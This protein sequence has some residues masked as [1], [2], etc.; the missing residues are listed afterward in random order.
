MTK[1]R[2]FHRLC[3]C[4]VFAITGCAGGGE[5]NNNVATSTAIN[6]T[7][8]TGVALTG[9]VTA[10]GA[11]GK[12]AAVTLNANG[13]FTLNS[14]ELT[15]PVLLKADDGNGTVLYS[16]AA[17]ANS[18][19][20]ITPLTTLALI[21]TDLSDNL[22][23]VFANW[24]GSANALTSSALQTAQAKVNA[25]LQTFFVNASL[26]ST[27][28][29]FLTT[30][31]TA[32]GTGIDAMLD[33]LDFGFS[34]TG[35]DF[36]SVVNIK[37]ANTNNAV[38]FSVSADASGI[39]IGGA[40]SLVPAV[41]SFSPASGAA[42]TSVTLAGTG[43]D[44]DKF[45]LVVSFANNVA[46]TITS[47]S[48]TQIVVTVPAGAV[49]GKITVTHG[50]SG[51]SA[52][53]ASDFTVTSTGGGTN[54]SDWMQRS[55]GSSFMLNSVAYGNA[56]FVAVGFGN[57]I[58]TSGDGGTW[59]KRNAP[60][61]NSYTL[62]SVIWDGAQFVTVG[63]V[64]YGSPT[65]T[66]PLIATSP[67][68]ITWTRRNWTNSGGETGFADLSSGGARLTAVG[69]NTTILSSTN[70]GVTWSAQTSPTIT[71]SYIAAYTGVASS[72]ST[73]V[74]V[75]R[76][77]NYKG[78]IIVSTDGSTWVEALSGLA[79]FYPKDVA[80]NGA[81]FIAVGASDSNFGAKPVMKTSVDGVTW[82]A[83]TLPASI[84]DGAGVL[85]DVTWDGAKYIAVGSDG[86][87]GTSAGK[88]FILAS[89]D[90]V[91]WT[92]DKQWSTAGQINSLAGVAIS[93]TK[94]VVVGDSL[95]TQ[96]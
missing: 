87:S 48:K 6:G 66:V 53:S 64:N 80:W 71:G 20:N 16:W 51:K 4:A 84:A 96:P 13:T 38:S 28:Y 81:L 49:T 41:A 69:L 90:G 82:A 75:G 24:S 56:T 47:A 33:A 89:P 79:T 94:A 68:G 11:N 60:D 37:L 40:S 65:G 7:A 35:A 19:A 85:N 50:I 67:D 30:P 83:Q 23:T 34:Y 31:F 10:V 45:H 61:A 1:Q 29:D 92:V 22:G 15:F 91:T 55:Y 12:Q 93:P 54:T 3:L 46:A 77:G 17:A 14:T 88:R 21:L 74:A 58:V 39:S 95:W 26:D 5:D 59:T 52:A 36:A 86:G 25:N 8:A 18:V 2:L 70:N 76:D 78:F 62:E 44:D 72:A 27:N 63:D 43:F 42:G 32:D 57:T 9:T 73:R